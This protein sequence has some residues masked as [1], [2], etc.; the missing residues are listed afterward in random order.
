MQLAAFILFVND[1]Y[2]VSAEHQ[3]RFRA[4]ANAAQKF[5]HIGLRFT[6]S[7]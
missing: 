1:V 6:M 2:R 4:N 5:C 7:V 3:P